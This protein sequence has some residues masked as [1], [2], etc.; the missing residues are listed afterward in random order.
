VG[1]AIELLR[2]A[3][4]RLGTLVDSN[5][6]LDIFTQ[7]ATWEQ[8]SSA[9]LA[10]TAETGPLYINKMIYAEVSIRLTQI[11]DLEEALSPSDFRRLSIRSSAAFSGR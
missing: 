4:L 8:W 7:D 3:R 10:E 6:L 1:K 5:V 2:S 11:E 9:T